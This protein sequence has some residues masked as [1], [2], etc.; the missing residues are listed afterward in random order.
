[1][2]HQAVAH[3]PC[4]LPH[5]TWSDPLPLQTQP[6]NRVPS[7]AHPHVYCAPQGVAPSLTDSGGLHGWILLLKA[8]ADPP[9]PWSGPAPTQILAVSNPWTPPMHPLLRCYWRLSPAEKKSGG[10]IQGDSA[11]QKHRRPTTAPVNASPT[12]PKTPPGDRWHQGDIRPGGR[13]RAG[14]TLDQ[15]LSRLARVDSPSWID[16]S[17]PT[18]LERPKWGRNASKIGISAHF[19]KVTINIAF[20]G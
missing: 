4:T 13:H 11:E 8:A 1:M 15:T 10:R 5:P 18:G 6:Q 20:F 7:L 12:C 19:C 17:C 2:A 16:R 3:G 14:R 9:Q